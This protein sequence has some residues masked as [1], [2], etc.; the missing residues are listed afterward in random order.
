TFKVNAT[1]SPAWTATPPT[2]V[3]TWPTV[4]TPDMMHNQT[5]AG[6]SKYYQVGLGTGELFA[7]YALPRYD[8]NTGNCCAS[9]SRLDPTAPVSP[10]NLPGTSLHLLYSSLAAY[11]VV[12]FIYRYQLDPTRAVPA[13]IHAA[14]TLNG[15]TGATVWYATSTLNPGGI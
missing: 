10:T 11:P 7:T 5:T 15:T 9:A 6:N 12:T 13:T 4:V 8:P 3:S 14:L 2:T 1:D